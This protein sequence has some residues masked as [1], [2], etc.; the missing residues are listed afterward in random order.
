MLT[1]FKV[2]QQ[3]IK[4]FLLFSAV[5]LLSIG[6]YQCFMKNATGAHHGLWNALEKKR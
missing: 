6:I 4:L 1:G 3:F 5:L 2:R